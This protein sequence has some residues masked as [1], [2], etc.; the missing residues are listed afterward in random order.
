MLCTER[1]PVLQR[2]L[3]PRRTGESARALPLP[4]FGLRRAASSRTKARA[5]TV[6]LQIGI[7]LLVVAG[8][9]ALFVS[10]RFRANPVALPAMIVT[11]VEGISG[12]SN[13]ATVSSNATAVML[14]PISIAAAE[15]LQMDS[16]PYLAPV[17]FAASAIL[18]TPVG[19]QTNTLIYGPGQYRFDD[20]LRVSAPW[21]L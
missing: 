9:V 10:E 14:A 5:H 3:P 20:F 17:T 21:N 2:L 1:Q 11:P 13:T 7:V 12:F 8:S 18:M 4:A 19:Y 6:T 16:R 15:M